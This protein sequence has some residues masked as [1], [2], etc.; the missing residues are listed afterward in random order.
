[1]VISFYAQF[2]WSVQKDV[3]FPQIDSLVPDCGNSISNALK[4]LQ[5]CN[6]LSG[7]THVLY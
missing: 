7:Y 4:L 2:S 1:M 3:A 5:S 6:K